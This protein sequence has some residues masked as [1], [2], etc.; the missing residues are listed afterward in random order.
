MLLQVFHGCTFAPITQQFAKQVLHGLPQSSGFP[1]TPR[2]EKATASGTLMRQSP[3]SDFL[4][5]RQPL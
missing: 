5:R 4:L 3:V 1:N 2:S